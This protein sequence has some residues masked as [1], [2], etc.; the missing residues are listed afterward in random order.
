MIALS[1][2]KLSYAETMARY[3]L[4]SCDFVYNPEVGI[5]LTV[6][7]QGSEPDTQTTSTPLFD[8]TNDEHTEA[9]KDICLAIV[10]DGF[11]HINNIAEVGGYFYVD[12]GEI[13]FEGDVTTLLTGVTATVK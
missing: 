2:L 11:P 4:I 1:P 6:Y 3:G 9:I 13:H 7:A 5:E 12:N 10:D 8:Y